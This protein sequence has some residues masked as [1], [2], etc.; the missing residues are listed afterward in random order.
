ADP[1]WESEH[2]YARIRGYRSA[3]AVPLLRHGEALG[4]ISVNRREPGG[5]TSDEVALLQTFADQAVIAIEN[6]RLLTELQARTQDRPRSAD[7]LTAPGEAGRALSSTLDLET[8][9]QTIVTRAVQV[10]GP[11]GCTIWEYDGAHE[12]FRLR[13]SHYADPDDAAIL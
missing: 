3:T 13:A 1:G 11:A 4:T 9:L 12:E 2:T 7:E 10:A 8:I 6:A 5:F